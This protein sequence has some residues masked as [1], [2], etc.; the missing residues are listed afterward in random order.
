VDG[1]DGFETG[2]LVVA[3]KDLLVTFLGYLIEYDQGL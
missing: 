2:Y 3:V 1:D